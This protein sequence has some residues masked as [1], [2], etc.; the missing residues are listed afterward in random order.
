MYSYIYTYICVYSLW[1]PSS[2]PSLRRYHYLLCVAFVPKPANGVGIILLRHSE[3][4]FLLLLLNVDPCTC[5]NCCLACAPYTQIHTH[6]QIMWHLKYIGQS[7]QNCMHFCAVSEGPQR[8]IHECRYGAHYQCR[9]H[10]AFTVWLGSSQ[11]G[12]KGFTFF[13]CPKVFVILIFFC[14]FFN[15][16]YSPLHFG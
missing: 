11:A 4:V 9:V 1:P 2:T 7:A 16:F 6:A 10:C 3:L 5:S 15:R 12:K 14:D 8:H 13:Y